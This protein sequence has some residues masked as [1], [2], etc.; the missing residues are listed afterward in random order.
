MV[1]DAKIQTV[2]CHFQFD[3]VIHTV[4]CHFQFDAVIHTVWCHF[5]FDDV[6]HTVWCHFQLDVVIHTVGFLFVY[7]FV[8]LFSVSCC[9]SYSG[10]FV[11]VVLVF[12]SPFSLML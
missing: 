7:F 5:Q 4:W 9:D 8:Y 12:F 1:F 10:V 6:I 2:W 3:A 11:V